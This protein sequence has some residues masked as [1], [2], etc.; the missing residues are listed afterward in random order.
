MEFVVILVVHEEDISL[1]KT[2]TKSNIINWN[3]YNE[4][5][6]QKEWQ[7]TRKLWWIGEFKTLILMEFAWYSL[8]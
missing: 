6:Y 3:K 7:V 5:N 4:M 1:T 2:H 8:T